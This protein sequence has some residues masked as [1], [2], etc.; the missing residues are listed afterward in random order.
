MGGGFLLK[1]NLQKANP[2]LEK[3]IRTWNIGL[4]PR[5]FPA[6]NNTT[7][8]WAFYNKTGKD[9]LLYRGELAR[10]ADLL[11]FQ[12]GKEL[13]GFGK[14]LPEGIFFGAGQQNLWGQ[15]EVFGSNNL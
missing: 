1:K 12:L 2:N 5:I 11:A 15:N 8:P 13:L 4:N 10:C 3:Q 14:F 6:T 7:K 9:I